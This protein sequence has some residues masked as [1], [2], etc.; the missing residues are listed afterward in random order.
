MSQ[1]IFNP[2][3]L[4]FSN[5][6]IDLEK[7]WPTKPNCIWFAKLIAL[8]LGFLCHW[9]ACA[10]APPIHSNCIWHYMQLAIWDRGAK[11]VRP[12]HV[13]STTIGYWKLTSDFERDYSSKEMEW[14][15]RRNC[16]LG[17]RF[18]QSRVIKTAASPRYSWRSSVIDS[19]PLESNLLLCLSCWRKRTAK[20]FPHRMIIML[21]SPAQSN[22]KVLPK[23]RHC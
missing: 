18:V 2:Q 9:S 11:T 7:V 8:E 16:V 21:K 10:A 6:S 17:C 4:P 5:P 1:P 12:T 14:W 3:D 20:K 19:P 15:R 22:L 23:A 13:R